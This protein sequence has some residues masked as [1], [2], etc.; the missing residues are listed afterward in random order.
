MGPLQIVLL[1]HASPRPPL[2][3]PQLP[4]IDL[5]RGQARGAAPLPQRLA[6]WGGPPLGAQSFLAKQ[7]PEAAAWHPT[8]QAFLPTTFYTPRSEARHHET[9]HRLSP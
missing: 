3:L 4:S 6:T 9:V 8:I 1:L 7:Q 5:R 2:P